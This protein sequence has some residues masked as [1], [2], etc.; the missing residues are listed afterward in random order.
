MEKKLAFLCSK[1]MYYLTESPRLLICKKV[2]VLNL[3]FSI[4]TIIFLYPL[5][6]V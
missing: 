2:K 4:L 1:R 6:R 5:A 3:D